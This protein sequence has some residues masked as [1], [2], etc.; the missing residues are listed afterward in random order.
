MKQ[1]KT[2]KIVLSAILAALVCVATYIIKI[3]FSSQGY[4]NIGDCVVLLC[5]WILTPSYA[6]LSAGIGSAL[7]DILSGYI[8]YALPTFIIKGLMAVCAYYMYK[9]LSC[10]INIFFARAISG[11]LGELIMILGYFITEIFMYGLIPA[12]LN[13]PGS[14]FQGIV[15]FILSI[16]LINIFKK[17]K[18]IK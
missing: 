5:G 9:I 18:I 4:F 1:T 16:I 14:A 11:L 13:I 10:R 17:N 7:A 12:A 15:G 6:F 2:R 8:I 3:P